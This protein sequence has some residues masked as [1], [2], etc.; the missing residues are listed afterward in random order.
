[1]NAFRSQYRRALLATKRTLGATPPDDEIAAIDDL[2]AAMRSLASLSAR[3]RAS[4]VL[5]DLLGFSSEEAGRILGIR[6]STIRQHQAR[7]HAALKG[8]MTDA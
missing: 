4:V 5:T 2:D 6:A 7:A 8:S 3:Q 1:M